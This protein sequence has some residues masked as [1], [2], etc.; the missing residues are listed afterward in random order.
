LVHA[1]VTELELD[2][3]LIFSQKRGESNELIPEIL[4]EVIIDIL[5]PSFNLYG[6]V[7]VHNVKGIFFFK[8]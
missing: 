5:N 4:D 1:D 2:L 3:Y 7:F 8:N 6:Y